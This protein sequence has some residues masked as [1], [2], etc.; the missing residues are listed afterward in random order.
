MSSTKIAL[1]TGASSGIGEA[2][3]KKMVQSGYKVY[4]TSRSEKASK[5]GI[6]FLKMNV[7]NQASVEEA[8]Q[9][10]LSK[11]SRLDVLVNSA[12]LGVIGSIEE[13]PV[14]TVKEVFETNVFGVMRV[15]QQVSKQM[16]KQNSGLIINISSI[17]GEV[18][19]P[20]RGIYSASKYALE[21]I[22]EALRMELK[23][24]GVQ[25]CVLQPGDFN[26]NI[27]NNRKG[28]RIP[29]NSPY[30]AILTSMHAQIEEG[31]KSSPEPDQVGDLVVKIGNSKSPKVR[32]RSGA[33][34]ETITPVLKRIMPS[35]LFEKLI[36]NHYKMK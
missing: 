10:L 22:T 31:M 3:A 5:F 35:K 14:D 24:F 8:I 25:V 16:R 7:D 9:K 29:E 12:G 13:L 27:A 2:I 17:A 6:E 28:E 26:T 19:L 18:S 30:E 15:C 20:F 33:F 34:M 32:Y 1:V 23:A 21:A 11:E 36:M 4:G